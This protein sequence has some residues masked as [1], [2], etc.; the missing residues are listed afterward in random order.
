MHQEWREN[1]EREKHSSVEGKVRRSICFRSQV[2]KGG[3]TRFTV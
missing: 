2:M 3:I 1:P